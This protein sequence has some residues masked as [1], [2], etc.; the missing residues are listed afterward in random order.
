MQI[1]TANW[2]RALSYLL[3]IGGTVAPLVYEEAS[4]SE[5]RGVSGCANAGCVGAGTG[6][7]LLYMIF[8]IFLWA[9]CSLVNAIAFHGYP[10]RT[11]WLRRL[12]LLMFTLPW[13]GIVTL[14]AVRY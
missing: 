6:E 4:R 9:F 2:L 7:G 13:V 11:S 12:E 5:Y 1:K 3:A 14:L 8:L 10:G